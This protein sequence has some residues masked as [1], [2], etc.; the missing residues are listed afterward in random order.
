MWYRQALEILVCQHSHL[1]A[2]SRIGGLVK[3]LTT[4]TQGRQRDERAIQICSKIY[5]TY[6]LSPLFSQGWRHL[7]GEALLQFTRWFTLYLTLFVKWQGFDTH[8]LILNTHQT[9]IML[10][11]V[12]SRWFIRV[13]LNPILIRY[14]LISSIIYI[15]L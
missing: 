11:S 15:K 4:V 6:W 1:S 8:F 2:S 3:R 10:R 14:I 5:I 7:L 9:P 13:Y 12:E